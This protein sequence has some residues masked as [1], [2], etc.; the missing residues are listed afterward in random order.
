M[1][2]LLISEIQITPTKPQNGLVA[3]ASCVINGQIY[4][5][6]IAIYTAPSTET[7]YRLVWPAKTLGRGI[8]IPIAHP[9]S[10]ESGYSIQK[11]IVTQYQKV[12]E[13]LGDE[14][15]EPKQDTA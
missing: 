14:V 1:D 6:S 11:Q 5:G 4:I 7:G 3:F 15:N 9:I 10:R 2:D 8:R 13:K 12:M